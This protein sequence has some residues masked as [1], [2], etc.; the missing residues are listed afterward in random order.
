MK[1][2]YTINGLKKDL[3]A[4]PVNEVMQKQKIYKLLKE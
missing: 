2:A 4:I 3:L 1:V